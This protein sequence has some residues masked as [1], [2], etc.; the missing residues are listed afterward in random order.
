MKKKGILVTFF[1]L[2]QSCT[3]P[4]SAHGSSGLICPDVGAIDD[5]YI[6]TR[7]AKRG[8]CK[9]HLS[10][11]VLEQVGFINVVM[12]LLYEAHTSCSKGVKSAAVVSIFIPTG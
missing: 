9:R 7:N 3:A 12:M 10:H 6:P 5:V 11:A 2:L 8:G 4:L 1:V